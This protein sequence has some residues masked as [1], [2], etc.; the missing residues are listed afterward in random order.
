MK[1]GATRLVSL[2]FQTSSAKGIPSV[3]PT[4]SFSLRSRVWKGR[5]NID[6]PKNNIAGEWPNEQPQPLQWP[7]QSK[8]GRF[9]CKSRKHRRVQSKEDTNKGSP[10]SRRGPFALIVTAKVALILGCCLGV[11]GLGV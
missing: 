3:R 7:L 8:A 9:R 10:Q 4:L 5:A 6:R 1:I 11:W 2:R